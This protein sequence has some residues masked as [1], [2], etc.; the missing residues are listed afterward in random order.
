M[1]VISIPA[2]ESNLPRDISAFGIRFDF[3]LSLGDGLFDVLSD[4]ERGRANRF[5]KHADAIRFA[6]SRAVLRRQ[7]AAMLE[8]RAEDIVFSY[9][10]FGRPSIVGH[11]NK[12]L[13]FNVSHSGDYALIALSARR[14]VG[15][16]IEHRC[17]KLDWRELA[18]TV[19][20]AE[21][22]VRI[23]CEVPNRAHRRFFDVWVAKEALLKADGRGISAGL[24]EFSV[25]GDDDRKPLMRGDSGTA[26]AL[27]RFSAQ[28]IR[29]FEE[30][31]ACIAWSR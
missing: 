1:Q 28:W 18:S 9:S 31:S 24:T 14:R 5:S 3:H 25:A 4:D 19:L 12:A 30:Y 16:D 11:G 17:S 2:T 21:E 22:A 23:A 20:S 7:L 10:P 29:V 26:V 15:V 8:K 13:D 6:T 27:R